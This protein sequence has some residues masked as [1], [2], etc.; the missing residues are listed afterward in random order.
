M[1]APITNI[2]NN[3]RIVAVEAGRTRGARSNPISR[4]GMVQLSQ[5]DQRIYSPILPAKINSKKIPRSQIPQTLTVGLGFPAEDRA[6]SDDSGPIS[7]R[8]EG[9]ALIGLG[10]P[11]LFAEV[12]SA[13]GELVSAQLLAEQPSLVCPSVWSGRHS[14]SL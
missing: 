10:C 13:W 8:R 14:P 7:T 5:K 9:L 3:R 1:R 2:S 4:F 12:A 11:V 6:V